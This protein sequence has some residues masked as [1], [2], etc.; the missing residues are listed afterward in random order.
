MIRIASLKTIS[1]GVV[2]KICFAGPA[3]SS[4]RAAMPPGNE[5]DRLKSLG[6]ELPISPKEFFSP[7]KIVS[8][9]RNFSGI[10]RDRLSLFIQEVAARK[11]TGRLKIGSSYSQATAGSQ[12]Q[13]TNL[14]TWESSSLWSSSRGRQIRRRPQNWRMIGKIAMFV[15]QKICHY[16]NWPPCSNTPSLWDTI[17][18]FRISPLLQAQTASC[19]SVRPI[20]TFGRP[21]TKTYKLSSHQ[22]ASSRIWKLRQSKRL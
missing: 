3:R 14:G 8:S 15:S 7:K 10:Y 9:P 11:R 18:E 21:G 2:L 19:S 22:A 12:A 16:H 4:K 6:L 20:P 5:R 17:A 1:A 13:K